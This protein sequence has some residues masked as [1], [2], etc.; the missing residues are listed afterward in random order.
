MPFSKDRLK[1]KI[2][3][4]GTT[5]GKGA[6]S[7]HKSGFLRQVEEQNND[8]RNPLVKGHILVRSSLKHT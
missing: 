1:S 5:R 3:V 6:I 4:Q 8:R 2:E 7:K